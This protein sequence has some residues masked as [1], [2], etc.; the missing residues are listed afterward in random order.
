MLAKDFMLSPPTVAHKGD[1]IG[2]VRQLMDE[3]NFQIIYILDDE[4]RLAGFLTYDS[5]TDHDEG[6]PIDP[7]VA[8]ATIVSQK[9]DPID[10]PVAQIRDNKLMVLPVVNEDRSLVGVL[11]PGALFEKFSELL[12]FGEGGTWITIETDRGD[13]IFDLMD[14]FREHQVVLRHILSKQ[15]ED[16]SVE[17]VVKVSDVGQDTQLKDDLGDVLA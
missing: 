16:D 15:N 17:L 1:T 14:V 6:A 2:Q 8:P 12:G 5:L 13:Q 7:F 9:D 4:D 11:T 3:N 10:K